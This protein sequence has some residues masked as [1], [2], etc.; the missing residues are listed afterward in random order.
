MENREVLLN[1]L[2]SFIHPDIPLPDLSSVTAEDW[3]DILKV[4]IEQ[5]IFP[6]VYEQARNQDGF[7]ELPEEYKKVFRVKTRNIVVV[8]TMKT[9]FFLSLYNNILE[10]KIKPLVVKGVV[11]RNIYPIPDYRMSSD[12][13]VLI[14]KK[15]F[16]A[17]DEFLQANGFKRPEIADPENEHEISY[18][19]SKMGMVIE[20]HLTLFPESSEAYGH[21]NRE[22]PA[23]HD[24]A[25]E[26]LIN[27][28]KV[29]TLNP[30]QHMLYLICHSVKH[31]I[32]SGFGIR[33]L[34]D[35]VLFAERYGDLIDW[36]E[37]IESTKK[38]HIY[39]FFM[40]LLC[41]GEKYLG[42]SWEKAKIKKPKMKFDPENII[43]DMFEGG[44]FGKN[45][46]ARVHSSNMTIEAVSTGDSKKVSYKTFF[47]GIKYIE[48]RYSY[49]K[50]HK[51]LLPVAWIQ[52]IVSYI[53]SMKTSG[54]KKTMEIGNR[55]IELLKKYDLVNKK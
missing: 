41:A 29:Y 52:R 43:N 9:D 14:D 31:F 2:N 3:M 18:V 8:Q 15:D 4:S 45:D 36:N 47:P 53:F 16:K 24:R 32:H 25:V 38:Q 49:V 26:E 1:I 10:S 42:F 27:G 6:I 44:V 35:M 7:K 50:K 33:Q 5:A 19:D 22:F 13:D 37:L 23:V 21:L 40:N 48:D 54:V 39:V 30:T 12:E 20:L 17:V 28:K 51:W 46:A 55:R 34:C 11:L